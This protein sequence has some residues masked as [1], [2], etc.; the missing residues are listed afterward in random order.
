MEPSGRILGHGGILEGA[1]VTVSPSHPPEIDISGW[2]A[3]SM[4]KT[5]AVQV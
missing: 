2:R 5:P 3:D 4:D 1:I